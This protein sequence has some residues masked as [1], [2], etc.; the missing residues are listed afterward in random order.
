MDKWLKWVK[1]TCL[2]GLM[3]SS[4]DRAVEVHPDIQVKSVKSDVF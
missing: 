1:R 3:K 2:V 4:S